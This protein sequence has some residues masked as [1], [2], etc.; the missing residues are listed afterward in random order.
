MYF[1]DL[2]VLGCF[3]DKRIGRD[4]FGYRFSS[5]KMTPELCVHKC[6][7]LNFPYAGVQYKYDKIFVLFLFVFAYIYKYF[8]V[9][10][11]FMF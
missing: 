10:F 1:I 9:E 7:S 6:H 3:K 5:K 2:K 11:W 4:L 8:V